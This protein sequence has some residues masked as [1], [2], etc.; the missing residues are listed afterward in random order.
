LSW[1]IYFV[2]KLS[3]FVL[4]S[5]NLLLSTICFG[6]SWQILFIFSHFVFV[7][8]SP[9]SL[10]KNKANASRVPGFLQPSSFYRLYFHIFSLMIFTAL[11]RIKYSF[12]LFIWN[13]WSTNRNNLCLTYINQFFQQ[14][15]CQGICVFL[16]FYST[17][18][19]LNH[20]HFEKHILQLTNSIGYSLTP[21]L[22]QEPIQFFYLN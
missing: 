22:P 20:E 21:R 6:A 3:F 18:F 15:H 1:F 13:N 10:Q 9:S 11:E 17:T 7:S 19:H 4:S 2:C 14:K 5:S 12:T 16:W 8:R